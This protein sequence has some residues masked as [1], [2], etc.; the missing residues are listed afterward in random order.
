[1]RYRF[2]IAAVVLQVLAL[3]FMAGEREWILRHGRTLLLRTAPIDPN[4]PM[5]GDYARLDYEISHVPKHLWEGQLAKTAPTPAADFGRAR[6][7]RV[8]A[9]LQTS[10]GDIAELVGLTDRK[11]ADGIFLRGRTETS[12]GQ[13]L[14]V[15]YGIEALFM[16]QGD[17]KKL[18][19]L[20]VSEKPGVP[21]DIEVAVS[22]AGVAVLKNYHWESLGITLAFERS[23]APRTDRNQPDN[24]NR[25][26]VITA[27]KVQLKNHGPNDVAI[28]DLPGG[29]SFRLVADERWQESRYRWVGEN[30]SPPA[31]TPDH[32]V[33][34][35]PGE[36]HTTRLDLLRA[37]WFVVKTPPSEEKAA[38]PLRDVSDPWSASFRVEYA[39]PSK[40]H[41]ASLPHADLIPHR[42]LRSRAF[43]PTAGMD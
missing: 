16:Q 36:A 28:V 33:V 19:E 20:R 27:L 37:E 6:E 8:Y 23:P 29:G 24:P 25:A 5:R 39:P 26:Q 42:R 31:A 41:S 32:V 35:K 15:R 40:A 18:E 17:A 14:Q 7:R 11:P 43:N 9:R 22:S 38:I 1:M 10:E 21:L 3:G 4:D 13:N 2:A 30:L 34:L 12:Y